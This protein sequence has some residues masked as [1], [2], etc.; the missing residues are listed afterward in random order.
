MEKRPFSPPFEE[1]K[2]LQA[3]EKLFNAPCTFLMGCAKLSQ[4]P[5]HD[6]VEVAIVGR[7]NVG[8][9]TLINALFNNKKLAKTSST[10]GR[11]REINYFQ[12]SGN[13]I[14]DLPGYGYAQTSKTLK[15]S[16]VKLIKEY[17]VGRQQLKRVYILIDARRDIK[18]IDIEFFKLL[19]EAA[20]SYFIVFTKSDKAKGFES[21][22]LPLLSKHPAAYPCTLLTSS[23]KKGGLR[24]LKAE[25]C[26]T[27]QNR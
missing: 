22:A 5:V 1:E 25:I 13:Y 7:S 11:T 10:P 4:L 14:V 24:Q 20:V 8:K 17:M 26:Y 19:D 2:W 23:V 9:S 15:E 12:F 3:G 16:W 6:S 18:P 21:T 27:L